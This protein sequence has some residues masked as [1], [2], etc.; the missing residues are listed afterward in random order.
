M[1]FIRDDYKVVGALKYPDIYDVAYAFQD[2][3]GDQ[4]QSTSRI[5]VVDFSSSEDE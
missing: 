5:I 2:E 4:R 3:D 1:E